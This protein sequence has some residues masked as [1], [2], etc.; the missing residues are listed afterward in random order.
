M[1]SGHTTVSLPRL[2][3]QYI[4]RHYMYD[5]TYIVPQG[6][7]V[8]VCGRCGYLGL[9]HSSDRGRCWPLALPDER[10]AAAQYLPLE[11]TEGSHG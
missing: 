4:N 7:S 5:C 8:P 6:L 9:G 3:N 1:V 11:L 2:R 10:R